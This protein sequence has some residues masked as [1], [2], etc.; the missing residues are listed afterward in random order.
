MTRSP[1][2]SGFFQPAAVPGTVVPKYFMPGDEGDHQQ[3]QS[4][5]HLARSIRCYCLEVTVQR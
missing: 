1:R 5:A 4:G 2:Q 3:Q